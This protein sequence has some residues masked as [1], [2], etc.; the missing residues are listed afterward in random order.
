[1]CKVADKIQPGCVNWK[2]VRDPTKNIYDMQG[3][4]GEFIRAS[5][6]K[7]DGLNLKMIAIGGDNLAKGIKIDTLASVW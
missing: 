2:A 1:M 3:N 6:D 7:N 4:N 5:K